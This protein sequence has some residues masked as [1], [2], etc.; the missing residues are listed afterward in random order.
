MDAV[1]DIGRRVIHGSFA[2]PLDVSVPP[3]RVFA[4][5]AD[6]SVRRRWFR[7]PSDPASRHY[8]LDFRAGGGEVAGGVFTQDGVGEHLEY[9]SHFLDVVPDERIAFTYEVIVDGRRRWV[10]LV[11]IELTPQAHGTRVTHTEQ[12]AFLEF[13]GDG[14]RDVA[15]LHGGVRLQLNGLAAVLEPRLAG[16]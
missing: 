11:T 12:Y 4:A 3:D 8:E 16:V 13:T 1:E 15:H 9:R 5:Y 7:I 10:S 14:R 2:V 6:A